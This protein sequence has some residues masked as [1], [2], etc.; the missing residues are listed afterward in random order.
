MEARILSGAEVA[1]LEAP[2]GVVVS[3]DFAPAYGKKALELAKAL[4]QGAPFVV[5]A[6]HLTME[7]ALASLRAGAAACLPKLISDASALSR[8][9][10]L[11]FKKPLP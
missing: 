1:A 7:T 6:E 10:G 11:A 2:V 3:W 4:S 5:L 8:E 9:L